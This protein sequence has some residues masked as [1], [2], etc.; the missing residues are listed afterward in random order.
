MG[1]VIFAS[2]SKIYSYE[3]RIYYYKAQPCAGQ[4][5]KSEKDH[6]EENGRAP[7]FRVFPP[8]APHALRKNFRRRTG[9][10][11]FFMG[12]AVWGNISAGRKGWRGV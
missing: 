5:E 1:T 10:V 12:S 11:R 2:N 6:R 9:F 7:S 3:A 8:P 4:I